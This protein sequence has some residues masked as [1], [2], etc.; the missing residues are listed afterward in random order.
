VCLYK[1]TL[2][3][4]LLPMLV[5]TRRYKTLLGFAGARWLW[6]F[7]HR[8]GRNHGWPEYVV[9]ALFW[10]RVVVTIHECRPLPFGIRDLYRSFPS[11]PWPVLGGA[12]PSSSL[13]RLR[14]LDPATGLVGTRW[15]PG[16]QRQTLVWAATLT[17]TARPE[18][19]RSHL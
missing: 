5:I 12:S 3:L 19:L 1:P 18:P 2:L 13:R 14:G 11:F 6:L 7:R 4:L 16:N 15:V 10:V 9:A 17:W 8:C